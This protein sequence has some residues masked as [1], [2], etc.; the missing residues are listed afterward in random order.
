MIDNWFQFSEK[1]YQIRKKN[2]VRISRNT[3]KSWVKFIHFLCNFTFSFCR[4][5]NGSLEVWWE[6]TDHS[7]NFDF[8]MEN[9]VKHQSGKNAT[10]NKYPGLPSSTSWVPHWPEFPVATPPD[11][12]QLSSKVNCKSEN[13]EDAVD[14]DYNYRDGAEDRSP[15]YPNQKDLN[16]LIKRSLSQVHCWSLEVSCHGTCWMKSV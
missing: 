13:E 4:M 16:D 6:P 5:R 9:P 14:P 15:Y 12:K 11:R 2:I 10:A 7:S 3:H 1:L 8:C